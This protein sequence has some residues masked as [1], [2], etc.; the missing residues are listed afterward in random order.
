MWSTLFVDI[1]H[2]RFVFG[3]RCCNRMADAFVKAADKLLLVFGTIRWLV[4][5]YMAAR[6]VVGKGLV[7]G[8]FVQLSPLRFVIS[9]RR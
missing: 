3:P 4:C 5:C 6:L 7:A 8:E 1:D 9:D 2:V